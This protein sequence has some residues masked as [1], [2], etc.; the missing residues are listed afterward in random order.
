MSFRKILISAGILLIVF[1][2]MYAWNRS[3]G[4]LDDVSV[5]VGLEAAGAVLSP[6]R[7]A[8]TALVGLWDD[9]IDLTAVRQENQ[10][11]TARVAELE[12]LMLTHR[13]DVAELRRLRELLKLPSDVSWTPVGARVLAGRMGPNSRLESFTINRG[14]VNGSIPGTPVV[15]NRGLLGRVQRASAHTSTVFLLTNPMSRIAVFTQKTRSPGILSGTGP[16]GPIEVLYVSRDSR[17]EVGEIL[18]TSGLDGKFPK[19]IPV[20]AITEVKPSTYTEF[21]IIAAEPLAD[22]GHIEEV[23]LL[24]PTGTTRPPEPA[25]PKPDFVGPL[26]PDFMKRGDAGQEQGGTQQ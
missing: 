11:L 19:G 16:S 15:T 2:S 9:Y 5:N 22:L 12:A 13:E 7:Q 1:L 26:L 8:Q 21:L 18:V 24:E 25:A 6:F 20:A 3:T 14:Y 17:V 23:L 10:R 4:V